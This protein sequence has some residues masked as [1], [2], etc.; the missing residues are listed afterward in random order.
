MIENGSK[1]SEK[2]HNTAK[3]TTRFEENLAVFLPFSAGLHKH[4]NNL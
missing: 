2:P 4:F 1:L 3:L